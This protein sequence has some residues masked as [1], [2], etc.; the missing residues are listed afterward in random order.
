MKKMDN[1]KSSAH[2]QN[3]II[4]TDTK[5]LV[6]TIPDSLQLTEDERSVLSKGLNFIPLTSHADMLQTRLD[7]EAFFRRLRLRAFF[8]GKPTTEANK[9]IFEKLQQKSSDWTPF[10]GQNKILDQVIDKCT[11][12]INDYLLNH[13]RCTTNN[14]NSDERKALQSLR[15]NKD[16]IIKPADKGG[17]VVAWS[18]D[19]YVGEATRQLSDSTTYKKLSKNPTESHQQ[20]VKSTVLDLIKQGELPA[21]ATNLINTNPDT[22]SFYML[23]KVHKPNNPGR[24][25]ISAHSCPTVFIA[26]YLDQIIQPMVH[27]LPTFVQDSSHA[28]RILNNLHLDGTSNLLFTIDVTSLYT[29]IPHNEGLAALRYHLER[30]TNKTPST[31]TILR[32]T[33]L[34][35][36][37]NNFSFEDQHYLQTKG[38]AMGSKAGCGYACLFVGHFEERVLSSYTGAIPRLFKRYIDDVFGI[39]CGP[40]EELDEFINFVANFSPSLKFTW[41]IS[42]QTVNFLDL[43]IS[44]TNNNISTTVHYKDTDSHNYLLYSSN[45]PPACKD[46]IPF[47]QFKR[48]RRICTEDSDFETQ[49]KTMSSFFE[50][51][52]YPSETTTSALRHAKAIDRLDAIQPSSQLDSDNDR[53]PLVITFHPSNAHVKNLIL[54]NYKTL[55]QH[56]STRDIFTHTPLTSYRRAKNLSDT[57]VRAKDPQLEA[58]GTSPCKR[59]RCKTCPFVLHTEAITNHAGVKHFITSSFTCTSKHLI[60]AIVCMRCGALY[61][62]ETKTPLSVRFSDHCRSVKNNVTNKPVAVHFNSTNHTISDMKVTA[63][64]STSGSSD[65]ERHRAEQLL[66]AK[67]S[68][69]KPHGINVKFD[70]F[71]CDWL[72]D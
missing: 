43:Q 12:D 6:I 8:H 53:I 56:P 37:L 13:R 65:S 32:L 50:S 61:I 55:S 2:R 46:S 5:N 48:L 42:T 51:R 1:L 33:E 67:L 22:A 4:A 54:K 44:I 47:A 24:P 34:V 41:Q 14:L 21:T 20:I 66:I 29:S 17:A 23:P 40:R 18:R 9:D 15:N 68:T 64:L 30:R 27:Q 69:L 57:L 36:N 62:G 71:K 45:H 31:D 3:P 19:L 72:L 11:H 39:M 38:V 26:D 60:Y 28:L 10:T 25:I 70:I 63:I 7:A 35:L 59:P 58:P 16:I 49:T 52:H